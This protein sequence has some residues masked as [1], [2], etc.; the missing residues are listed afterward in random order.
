MPFE[1]KI[2]EHTSDVESRPERSQTLREFLGR[3]E[4]RRHQDR[5][6]DKTAL[7]ETDERACDEESGAIGHEGLEGGC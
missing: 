1:E 2:S 5:T 3:V 7:E 4:I 6:G